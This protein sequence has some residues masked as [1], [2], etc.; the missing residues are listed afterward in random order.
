MVRLR[1]LLIVLSI[2]IG[3]RA[4]ELPDWVTPYPGAMPVVKATAGMAVST[5][6]T[7]ASAEAVI[8]HY[9]GVWEAAGQAFAA[10]FNGTGTSIRGTAAECDLLVVVR[11]EDAGSHV[12]TTCATRT[13]V[14]A[15]DGAR[16]VVSSNGSVRGRRAMPPMPTP[17]PMSDFDNPVHPFTPRDPDWVKLEWPG[18][19]VPMMPGATKGLDIRETEDGKGRRILASRYR[20]TRPMSELYAY[21]QNV[22]NTYGFKVVD[23]RLAT[24]STIHGV[25]QNKTGHVKGTYEPRG[26]GRGGM[27]TVARFSRENLN[28]P[29][30][31]VLEVRL[32][33]VTT[34]R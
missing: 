28:D 22:M 19:F 32:E 14:A 6:V 17:R 8:A 34:Q 18:W 31:V 29:I 12:K 21:Y 33:Q 10:N 15:T 9:K 1:V 30:L 25:Q 20:T 26:M 5:Y 23:S 13:Q 11:E 4:T 16:E 3:L 27:A 7:A 2:S 24:G